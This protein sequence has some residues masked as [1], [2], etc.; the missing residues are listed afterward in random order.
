MVFFYII[1][2]MA[3]TCVTL[4]VGFGSA[5]DMTKFL[6]LLRAMEWY[7]T[8]GHSGDIT[9]QLDG[10]G[11][12]KMRTQVQTDKGEFV[13]LADQ[14]EFNEELWNILRRNQKEVQS[15]VRPEVRDNSEFQL[16]FEG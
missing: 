3:N 6:H 13:D 16:C 15:H 14:V 1:T 11:A 4:K 12:F 10:D 5:R 2:Y 9:L 7:G 8:V